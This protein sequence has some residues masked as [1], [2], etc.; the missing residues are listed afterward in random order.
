MAHSADISNNIILCRLATTDDTDLICSTIDQ[1]EFIPAFLERSIASSH[2]HIALLNDSLIVGYAVLDYS[3]Y[4]QAFIS[5]LRVH[6]LYRRQGIGLAMMQY[7][8]QPALCTTK[9]S[10]T[11]TNLSN[12]A[13][14]SLLARLQYKLTGVIH[15]LDDDGDSELVYY[16]SLTV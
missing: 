16:K 15:N 12:L 11:S 8:E 6:P 3:F 13:M 1:R 4:T 7:L 2:C 9:K 5:M 14:Q 10:F